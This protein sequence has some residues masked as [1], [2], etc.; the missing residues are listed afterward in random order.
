MSKLTDTYKNMQNTSVTKN[1]VIDSILSNLIEECKQK[2][3]K[4]DLD[5]KLPEEIQIT[6]HF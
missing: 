3:I 6:L 2:N 5:I 1:K 4:L